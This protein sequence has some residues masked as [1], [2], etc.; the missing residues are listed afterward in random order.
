M[1]STLRKKAGDLQRREERIVQAEEELK[2][3]LQEV[4]R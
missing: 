1:E 4:S 3:K 2:M